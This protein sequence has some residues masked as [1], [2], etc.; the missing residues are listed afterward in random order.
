MMS[1]RV[2]SLTL[3]FSASMVVQVCILCR[4]RHKR[5]TFGSL[6][7]QD[8]ASL[9]YVRD[10]MGHSSIQI[11]VD[12]YGH[13]IPGA[14]INW[15]DG[16]DRKTTQQ[17]NATP[18]QLE[19]EG[20]SI[21]DFLPS[22]LLDDALLSG[23]PGRTRIY[24]QQLERQA[25]EINGFSDFRAFR[26]GSL[27]QKWSRLLPKL[28]PSGVI[29]GTEV[30]SPSP[31]RSIALY[32]L[33]E[34]RGHGSFRPVL[35]EGLHGDVHPLSAIALRYYRSLTLVPQAGEQPRIPPLR[36]VI[37]NSDTQRLLLPD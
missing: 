35:G 34:P 10:Q 8:G 37:M 23:G 6:L 32:F 9:A 25:P 29:P 33:P 17:Q 2:P 5:H 19:T 11:T 4:T 30:S 14:D 18:A 16:L 7:I 31:R 1:L 15:V 28:L 12:T 26:L 27:R 36:T 24:N 22:Q 20:D 13:L 3:R 21:P